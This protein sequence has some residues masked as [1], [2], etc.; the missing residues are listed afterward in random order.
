M[1][2]NAFHTLTRD[3]MASNDVLCGI[4]GQ[5]ISFMREAEWACAKSIIAGGRL[6]FTKYAKVGL[7]MDNVQ[8]FTIAFIL[9]VAIAVGLI[10][11]QV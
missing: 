11:I 7:Q 8:I 9:F 3:K 6:H 5:S 1:P 4:H 2:C 10:L